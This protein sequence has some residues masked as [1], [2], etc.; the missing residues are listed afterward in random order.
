M[1]CNS[2]LN[3]LKL[4]YTEHSIRLYLY[5]TFDAAIKYG[6][7]ETLKYMVDMIKPIARS[8]SQLIDFNGLL[9][10]A[11]EHCSLEKIKYIC[12]EFSKKRLNYYFALAVAPL[13]GDIE[14]V[15][16]LADKLAS[17]EYSKIRKKDYDTYGSF[18]NAAK[19]GR[20]DMIEWL[21]EHRSQ[22]REFS[23]M[24]YGAIEG[25]H[26]HVV[27]YLLDINEPIRQEPHEEHGTLF[28]YSILYNQLAI[29]KLLHQH[30]IR[31]SLD[32]PIDFASL[33]ENIEMLAWL[34]ANT[35]VTASERVV[36]N[37]ALKN[38]MEV[39]KWLKQHRTEGC[40]HNAF[41]DVCREG[42]IEVAQW[43]YR[44]QT[45]IYEPNDAIN[46]AVGNGHL[47]L[48]K[49][50]FTTLNQR[51]STAAMNNAAVNNH[52]HMIKWL[53]DNSLFSF[54]TTAIDI[55]SR[56]DNLQMI[57]W[58][59]EYD[60][61]VGCTERALYSAASRGRLEIMKWLRENRTE[62]SCLKKLKHGIYSGGAETINW[63]LDN[64]AIDL[65]EMVNHSRDIKTIKWLHDNN[66]QGI[67]NDKSMESAI[68]GIQF[69]L[70]KWLYE[71]RSECQCT[72]DGFVVAIETG[73]TEMIHY[74]LGKHPE[75]AN[76][77]SKPKRHLEHYFKNDDIEMIE[78]LLEN[79]NFP[80]NKLNKYQRSIQSK[81]YS[82]ISNQLLQDH[83]KKKN[84]L[85]G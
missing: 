52:I 73:Y 13:S 63:A 4:Y 42:Y 61:S 68:K 62:I 37:A 17:C 23:S 67:F 16:Y 79:I 48:A 19:M 41:V 43:L 15:K 7:F 14:I 66:I 44:N 71:N 76:Q 10:E 80:L 46:A 30:N 5:Q 45:I 64:F 25:G 75:F 27:Q 18:D 2:Y 1:A 9:Y 21:A 85:F 24:Y 26:L 29:A 56:S 74:L 38:N 59:N 34:S 31:E 65:D 70:V 35:T 6:N 47:E 22:D 81:E 58:L 53:V 33:N 55:L 8:S 12:E 28:D 40:S 83:I 78:F 36:D 77:L 82:D 57:K 69:P 60:P 49:W 84:D 11:S 32:T 50:L 51:P 72:I 39:L 54:S 20:I 3:E